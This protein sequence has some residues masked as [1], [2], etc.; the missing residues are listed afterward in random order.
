MQVNNLSTVYSSSLAA[1]QHVMPNKAQVFASKQ[2]NFGDRHSED[3]YTLTD[4]KDTLRGLWKLAK[5]IGIPSLLLINGYHTFQQN[6]QNGSRLPEFVS[7]IAE[8]RYYDPKMDGSVVGD[9]LTNLY[10]HP[11]DLIFARSNGL[12]VRELRRENEL[13]RAQVREAT[14]YSIDFVEENCDVELNDNRAKGLYEANS[15]EHLK[16]E[17]GGLIPWTAYEKQE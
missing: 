5:W 15:A 14:D 1:N 16:H 11:V 7:P 13:L 3:P 12:E 9:F 6:N 17:H 4:I 2:P 8:T 10:Q